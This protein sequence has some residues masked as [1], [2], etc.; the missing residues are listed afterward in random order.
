[1]HPPFYFFHTSFSSILS[2]NFRFDTPF[3]DWELAKRRRRSP[4]EGWLKPLTDWSIIQVSKARNSPEKRISCH[5]K[6]QGIL[7][8]DSDRMSRWCWGYR[9]WWS[10]LEIVVCSIDMSMATS[11]VILGS[12]QYYTSGHQPVWCLLKSCF[13]GLST[14][15]SLVQRNVWHSPWMVH[16]APEVPKYSLLPLL[17]ASSRSYTALR[18]KITSKYRNP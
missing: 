10:G 8:R 18:L 1:M 6:F 11:D 16:R 2:S 17:L 9:R 7:L 4:R 15:R 5:V 3:L 14:R 13:I 12:T